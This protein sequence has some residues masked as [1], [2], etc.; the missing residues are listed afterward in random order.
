M[1]K[2]SVC[3]PL[4]G[5]LRHLGANKN[6]LFQES[7]ELYFTISSKIVVNLEQHSCLADLGI[8]L[9]TLLS[10]INISELVPRAGDGDGG[11]EG[12]STSGG[13]SCVKSPT[14]FAGDGG[15]GGL[16]EPGHLA[17]KGP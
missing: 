11:N 13:G 2:D 16:S 9:K 12:E 1:A 5:C 8:R 17:V 14:E 15:R 4:L 10:G 7:T 3:L 6:S